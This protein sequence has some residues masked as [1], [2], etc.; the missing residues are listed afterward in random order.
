MHFLGYSSLIRS[1]PGFLGYIVFVINYYSLA[2]VTL[3]SIQQ[4]VYTYENNRP[5]FLTEFY[6]LLPEKVFGKSLTSR[7]GTKSGH[8]V[9]YFEKQ[10]ISCTEVRW[11][12]KTSELAPISRSRHMYDYKSCQSCMALLSHVEKS[13]KTT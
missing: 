3:H 9:D 6:N 8:L 13:I 12:L 1:W 11:R 2:T 7:K 4:K 10:Q 5:R